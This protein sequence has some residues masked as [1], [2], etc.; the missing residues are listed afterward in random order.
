MH[1]KPRMNTNKHKFGLVILALASLP[2]FAQTLPLPASKL[3]LEL[4][5]VGIDEHLGREI[6]LD[7][8]FVAE[9]GYPVPLR[10]YF[11]QGRP[12]ILNLVYYS[13]PMLCNLILNGETQ[14]LREIPWMP[15]KEFEVVTISFDPRESFDLAR[16]KKAVYLESYNRPAPGWHFLTDYQGN[17]KRLAQLMGFNY[18][19]DPRIEQF[20]HTAAIFVLTPTGRISRYLYGVRYRARD[21]RFALAEASEGKTTMT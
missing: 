7:L 12:V 19:Y 17:A 10:N 5:G 6:D 1:L 8:T 14:V 20:A 21:L 15:G 13:C 11:H 4:E 16:Q 18:R 2:G 9:N 3:P